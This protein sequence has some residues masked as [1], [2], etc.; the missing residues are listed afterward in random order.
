MRDVN[1]S[2]FFLLAGPG[3][4]ASPM[5]MTWT[6]STWT[7]AGKQSWRLPLARTPADAKAALNN[8]PPVVVDAYGGMARIAVQ[9]PQGMSIESWDGTTWTNLVDQNNTAIAPKIGKFVA[10]SLG[11][12]RLALVASDGASAFLELFDLSGRWPLDSPENPS[13]AFPLDSGGAAVAAAADGPISVSYTHLT[14][15][16]NR[17]V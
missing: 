8:S 6:A 13:I 16:T 9:N 5:G 1:R 11:G 10:M 17:E 14:L 4:W 3:D 2:S 15:P 7:L 12:S